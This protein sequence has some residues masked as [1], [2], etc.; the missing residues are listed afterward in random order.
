MADL[1][2]STGASFGV[3]HDGDADRAVFIDNTGRFIEENKEFALIADVVCARKP[4]IIVTPVSSSRLI[5]QIGTRHGCMV[6]Y[7]EVGSI[8]VARRMLSLIAAGK[9]VVF[10]GEGN[11]GL[12]YADHQFC[13]DG[14]MTAAM[15]VDLLAMKKTPLSQLVDNLPPSVML[16][17]KFHTDKAQALLQAVK[18]KFSSDILNEIDGIRIDRPDVW[19]LIRPSGT[20]PLVRLYIESSREEIASAFEKEILDCIHPI[21]S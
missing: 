18:R 19:A 8:Y 13:R 6:E 4:G 17:H 3:A 21:L 12:I 11:G 9:P 14:G 16:K 10:G 20:E 2:V 1:V 7:T 15:M 5:E